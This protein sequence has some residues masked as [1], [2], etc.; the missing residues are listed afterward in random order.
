[1]TTYYVF[2]DTGVRRYPEENEQFCMVSAKRPVVNV[3][4]GEGWDMMKELWPPEEFAILQLEAVLVRKDDAGV[5]NAGNDPA[6]AKVEPMVCTDPR[7]GTPCP[8]PCASCEDDCDHAFFVPASSVGSEDSPG[9]GLD[10]E[11]RP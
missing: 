2:V 6:P 10:G 8:L 11:P 5:N 9:T 1:M 3:A 4:I 7:H